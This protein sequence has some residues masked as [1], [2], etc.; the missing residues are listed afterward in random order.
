MLGLLVAIASPQ[1]LGRL[2]ISPWCC[3]AC[4]AL[5]LLTWIAMRPERE[6]SYLWASAARRSL[7]VRYE[8]GK[9]TVKRAAPSEK[10]THAARPL[11]VANQVPRG[12]NRGPFQHDANLLLSGMMPPRRSADTTDRLLRASCTAVSSLLLNGAAMSQKS[13]LTQSA[14]S[15]R[16]RRRPTHFS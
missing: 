11:P 14:H 7:Q 10:R 2:G 15:V 9:Y 3:L 12:R 5:S 8:G 16:K 1:I 6:S 13:S 4:A